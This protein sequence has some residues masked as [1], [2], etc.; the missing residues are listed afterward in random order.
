MEKYRAPVELGESIMA[1]E[2]VIQTAEMQLM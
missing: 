1:D 2:Y